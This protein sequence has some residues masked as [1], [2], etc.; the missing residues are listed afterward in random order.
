MGMRAVKNLVKGTKLV[1]TSKKGRIF[2]KRGDY[3]QAIKDFESI[4]PTNVF[5]GD[6]Y[7]V[8]SM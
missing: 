4:R 5:E 3:L 8:R 1:S 7:W 6:I 2:E